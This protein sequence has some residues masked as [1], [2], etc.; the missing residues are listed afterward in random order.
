MF[1]K[2]L[3]KFLLQL[4]PRVATLTDAG[5][6]VNVNNFA[7]QIREAAMAKLEDSDYRIRVHRARGDSGQ[8]EAERTNSATGNYSYI[9]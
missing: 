3:K 2:C 8:N 7:V 4:R 9:S 1:K 5:P 6:G